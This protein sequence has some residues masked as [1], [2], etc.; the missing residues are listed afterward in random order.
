MIPQALL[1]ASILAVTSVLAAAADAPFTFRDIA[2]DHLDIL[3]GGKV[4]A[5]YMYAHDTSSKERHDETYKPFLHV[6]DAEGKAP[7]TKGPGGEFTHHRG[8]FIGWMT[9][10]VDG[11]KYDRWHMKGGDQVHQKFSGQSASEKSAAFTSEVH[12]MNEAGQPFVMEERTITVS[13]GASLAY[14][15]VD[16]RSKLKAPGAAVTLGGD[17]EHAGL[18]FRP[19][20]EVDRAATMYLYPKE[21]ADAH[22]DL[23]YPWVA[24]TFSLN[25]AKFSVVYL[26]HPDNPTGTRFSAY[27]NYGR[28]G[29]F[30]TSEIPAGGEKT[31]QA[32]ILVSAGEMPTVEDIQKAA[33]A[34]TGRQ[35]PAPKTTLKP[36]ENGSSGKAKAPA[37][38]PAKAA[39]PAK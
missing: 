1:S 4:V 30:F 28:F 3:R 2:G 17:P 12:W 38:K 22:K 18:Q 10:T 21:N 15:Q 36:A 20:N 14:V 8:L 11:K 35:D 13:P 16:M 27:R 25:G 31:I 24:E 34:Y 19:A 32:R 29:G 23:D 33:N 39:A 6:F 7:I 37:P 9:M 5:R 26:N